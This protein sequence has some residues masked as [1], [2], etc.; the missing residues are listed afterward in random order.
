MLFVLLDIYLN[1][2]APRY[3]VYGI[4]VYLHVSYMTMVMSIIFEFEALRTAIGSFTVANTR[5]PVA[6]TRHQVN[7]CDS[8]TIDGRP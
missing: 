2:I 7:F 4:H 8:E 3:F 5:L 1:A 6:A